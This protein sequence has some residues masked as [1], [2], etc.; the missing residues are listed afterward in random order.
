MEICSYLNFS[1]QKGDR[2]ID[3]DDVDD[4]DHNND[5]VFHHIIVQSI[6]NDRFNIT[7][8]DTDIKI[9]RIRDYRMDRDSVVSIYYIYRR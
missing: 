9:F 5:N 6:L 7:Y 8:E 2:S 4:E 1:F 3:D